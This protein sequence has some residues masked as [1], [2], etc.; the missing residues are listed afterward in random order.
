[1]DFLYVAVDVETSGLNPTADEILEIVAI[2]CNE[3]GST[4]GI[5]H[6]L[7]RPMAGHTNIDAER[8]NHISWD[9]VKD[10]PNY[11]RDAVR[12]KLAKFIGKRTVI[13]HNIIKFDIP[14]IRIEP[15]R[16]YDTLLACRDRYRG[17]NKL[18]TA[19]Q[20]A[21]IEWDDSGAH[22]AEYDVRKNIELFAKLKK[23]ESKETKHTMET[24]LFKYF[25]TGEQENRKNG[26]V[27]TEKDKLLIATQPYSYSRINL[28]MQ[29]PFKWYMQYIKGLKGPDQDFHVTGKI[30][31]LIAEL[32]GMWCYQ[33]T[34]V[35]KFVIWANKNKIVIHENEIDKIVS[36]FNKKKEDLTLSDYGRYIYVNQSRLK[37]L[38]PTIKSFGH[39]IMMIED[40]VLDGEFESPTMPDPESYEKL[41]Q[42]AINR[43]RCTDPDI[44]NDVRYIMSRFYKLKNF[45]LNRRELIVTEKRI[46]YDRQW[47]LLSDFYA[48][49]VFIRGVI[50][51][52]EYY[53]DY[54]I[55]TDYKSSR[56]MLTEA[57]LKSD[58]Q[59]LL[60]LLMIYKYIPRESYKKIVIRIEYIRFNKTVE[61]EVEDVDAAAAI[62]MKWLNDGIQMIESEM[63]K[64]EGEAFQPQR[65]QYCSSCHIGEDGKCP[66]FSKMFISN[67][68]DPFQFS[69][70]NVDDCIKAWKRIE[71]N[72]TENI[73]LLKLCKEFVKEYS[74][75][76]TIDGKAYLDFYPIPTREYSPAKLLELVEKRGMTIRDIIYFFKISESEFDKLCD[77]KKLTISNSELN[78]I[79]REK[80]RHEFDA[81]TMEEIEKKGALNAA[82]PDD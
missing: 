13:G 2:E 43:N 77:K 4:G 20:R 27:I 72:K 7:C 51:L 74:N 57:Q 23:L 81:L 78:E 68:E 42:T 17:G 76:I 59:T 60:Y 14:F 79:S 12:E 40:E 56:T 10:C 38:Y 31:H 9:M 26:V 5:F 37:D 44:I 73:R 28:F 50:D 16:V 36:F 15:R 35:S 49:N 69:I 47:N 45:Q 82:I 41:V 67:I 8:I 33:E 25:Q 18:K 22:R 48:N 1:M 63:L 34:F 70:S 3:D 55:I 58:V 39:F 29:C 64:P 80:T 75:K 30:C 19:C 71:T 52:I 66:L 46:A 6:Q 54:I 32:S 24:P 53:G 21:G 11:L 61:Y 65:N 62:A